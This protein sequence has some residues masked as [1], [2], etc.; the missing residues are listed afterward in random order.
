MLGIR[1]ITEGLPGTAGE[2][3]KGQKV[4]GVMEKL[5]FLCVFPGEEKTQLSWKSPSNC[6]FFVTWGLGDLLTTGQ[7]APREGLAPEAIFLVQ[8]PDGGHLVSGG[9]DRTERAASSPGLL[10]GTSPA[11]AV[12]D[13]RKWRTASSFSLSFWGSERELS[14]LQRACRR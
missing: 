2:L 6:S 8:G 9:T 11:A 7:K 1:G 12:T 3:A 4:I 13:T 10:W 14:S 5:Y